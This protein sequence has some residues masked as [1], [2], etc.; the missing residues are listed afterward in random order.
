MVPGGL[1]AIHWPVSSVA[2][3][4]GVSAL[5]GV[6]GVPDPVPCEPSPGLAT[7]LLLVSAVLVACSLWAGLLV[8]LPW[9]RRRAV[10]ALVLTLVAVALVQVLVVLATVR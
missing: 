3:F 8:A 1:T 6:C 2:F 10:R 4:F 7:G 5:E 9:A